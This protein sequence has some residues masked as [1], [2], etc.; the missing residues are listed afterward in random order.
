MNT[1]AQ[2]VDENS[3]DT[4]S[5]DKILSTDPHVYR[6]KTCSVD[7]SVDTPKS[8][9]NMSDG[10][11]STFFSLKNQKK[12]K[13][14]NRGLLAHSGKSFEPSVD[15]QETVDIDLSAQD[16]P[17]VCKAIFAFTAEALTTDR[18]TM[19]TRWP[20]YKGKVPDALA[21]D[22]VEGVGR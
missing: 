21:R 13:E 6:P 17:T 18:A 12:E 11:L 7:T 2:T 1:W 19:R 10:P 15:T 16:W 5:V 8:L 9:K 4:A 14:E 3:V 20:A 22:I